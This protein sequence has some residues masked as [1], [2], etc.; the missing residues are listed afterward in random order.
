ME[1]GGSGVCVAFVSACV[2]LLVCFSF[3]RMEIY[4]LY[5]SC[6]MLLC[7]ICVFHILLVI[8]SE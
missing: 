1:D 5:T 6:T 4:P 7:P 2:S 8:I 3:F